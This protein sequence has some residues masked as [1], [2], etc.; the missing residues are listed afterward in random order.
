LWHLA[1]K[2]SALITGRDS[3]VVAGRAA[4]L[5]IGQVIQRAADKGPA[6]EEI[7]KQAEL[8]SE[9]VCY[10]GDDV[11]DL[12]VLVRCGLPV[13]VAD[14]CAEVRDQARFI[15][16]NPGGQGAVREVVE[17]ILRC[18]GSWAKLLARLL[19]GTEGHG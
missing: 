2:R 16:R 14:A 19:E 8:V 6:F 15:T 7:M 11:P 1:G 18:Q 4:E 17:L 10:V 3:P 5:G 13:A 9:Q 12:P